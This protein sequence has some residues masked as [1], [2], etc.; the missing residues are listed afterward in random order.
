MTQGEK[1]AILSLPKHTA[2]HVIVSTNKA[3]LGDCYACLTQARNDS[4]TNSAIVRN[5]ASRS[6]VAQPVPGAAKNPA[7]H[8]DK[9]APHSQ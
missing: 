5:T 7:P 3:I 2:K 8:T 9:R 4:E 6:E 1:S